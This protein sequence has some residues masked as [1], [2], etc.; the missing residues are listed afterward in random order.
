M[1]NMLRKGAISCMVINQW[2][3]IG[4]ARKVLVL[5]KQLVVKN[6]AKEGARCM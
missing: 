2:L 4:N 6:K 1:I 3:V 5:S